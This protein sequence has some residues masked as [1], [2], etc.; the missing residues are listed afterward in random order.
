[1]IGKEVVVY[2]KFIHGSFNS[3]VFILFCY[4]G[5]LA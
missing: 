1:M 2:L 4:Q 5:G 3:L